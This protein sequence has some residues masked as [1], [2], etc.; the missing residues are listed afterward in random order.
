MDWAWIKTLPGRI[1]G[2]IVLLLL[3]VV[4]AVISTL[5]MIYVEGGEIWQRSLIDREIPSSGRR[6]R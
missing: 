1:I 2:T 4:V 6:V 5:Y 3:S